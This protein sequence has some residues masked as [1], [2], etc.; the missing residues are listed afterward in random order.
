[1][2]L[3]ISQFRI[4]RSQW[5]SPIRRPYVALCSLFRTRG[6][7][8]LLLCIHPNPSTPALPCG[9]PAAFSSAPCLRRSAALLM[10]PVSKKAW[11]P[12]AWHFGCVYSRGWMY[13]IGRVSGLRAS[14][15]RHTEC[16]KPAGW[17]NNG[18]VYVDDDVA[19]H[20][21]ETMAGS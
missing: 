8:W 13:L 20:T 11:S 17:R 14:P 16:W 9:H 2:V 6:A 21:K 7:K 3:P 19:I 4:P 5:I 12:D 1:M 10:P 18:T 15:A